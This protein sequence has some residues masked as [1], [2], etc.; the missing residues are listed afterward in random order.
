[1]GKC[2]TDDAK[3]Q[4]QASSCL[5]KLLKVMKD[6]EMNEP[7]EIHEEHSN[8]EQKTEDDADEDTH[9]QFM[10][11]LVHSLTDCSLLTRSAS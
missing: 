6:Q 7:R 8:G 1:M 10:T 5:C 3:E 2:R 4:K 11:T 9:L